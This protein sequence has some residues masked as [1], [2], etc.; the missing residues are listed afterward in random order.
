VTTWFAPAGS[1]AGGV[2]PTWCVGLRA[3]EDARGEEAGHRGGEPGCPVE[4]AQRQEDA[5]RAEGG[6][7]QA[8]GFA[9]KRPGGSLS[10]HAAHSGEGAALVSRAQRL[11]WDTLRW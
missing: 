4:C 3:G 5:E 10:S 11:G 8:G 2:D 9:S 1:G 7:A 6:E